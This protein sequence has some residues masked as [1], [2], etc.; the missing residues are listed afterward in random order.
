MEGAQGKKTFNIQHSMP[1]AL[2]FENLRDSYQM[3]IDTD[4][5]KVAGAR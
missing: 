4:K 3:Q 1:K 2:R 5:D